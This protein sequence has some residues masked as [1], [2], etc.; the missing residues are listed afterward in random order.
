MLRFVSASSG[1]ALVLDVLI[2]IEIA[3]KLGVGLVEGG[4]RDS[5]Q[6]IAVRE[7]R[8]RLNKN[9]FNK[10]RL[11]YTFAWKKPMYSTIKGARTVVCARLN[12][13]ATLA[14]QGN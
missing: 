4:L 5:K 7:S 6:N 8:I 3:L 14:S 2:Q 1:S 10:C 11:G 9:K 13:A 12:S